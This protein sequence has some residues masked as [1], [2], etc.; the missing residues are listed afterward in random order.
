MKQNHKIYD[1][2]HEN[3]SGLYLSKQQQADIMNEITGGQKVKKKLTLGLV[4]ALVL[5][6]AAV[7]ALAV[8]LWQGTA[9]KIA[10][11][12]D[13]HGY[14]DTW[15]ASTKAELI[16][17][18]YE[19]GV[20]KDSDAVKRVLNGTL[21]E[22]TLNILSDEIMTN[23]VS[24]TTDTVT[25]ESILFQ[26]H[27]DI[28]TW[29]D[30]EKVWYENMLRQNNLLGDHSGYSL[31]VGEEISR[32]QAIEI[33]KKFFTDL[34]II[35]LDDS[36]SEA[37]FIEEDFDYWYGE[38]QVSTIGDRYWSIV[39]PRGEDTVTVDIGADG[40]VNGYSIPQIR[41]L[42]LSGSFPIETD[43]STENASEHARQAVAQTFGLAGSSIEKMPIKALFTFVTYT[44]PED[45]P[46]HLGQRLWYIVIND[47]YQVLVNQNSEIISC[48]EIE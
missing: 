40:S 41:K 26:L 29:S 47:T 48:T 17:V 46:M 45:A 15:N 10:P 8:S 27:G 34:D 28:S 39:W 2:I 35:G 33:A 32:S 42:R 3:L 11:L 21:D 31:P 38:T 43:I 1:S 16:R 7:T 30:E 4:L 22:Q 37:T 24:G 23:Y 18:L 20:L 14:Y 25:L 5:I 6:L 9:E 19:A 36:T 44:Y 12:E 13:Q